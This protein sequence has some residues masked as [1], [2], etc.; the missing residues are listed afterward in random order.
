[1]L[2]HQG[3][4][5]GNEPT[6]LPRPKH[7]EAPLGFSQLA[8]WQLYELGH[9]HA[10]RTVSSATRLLGALDVRLL[11]QSLTQLAHRHEALRTRI[12]I[13]AGTPVQIIDEARGVELEFAD[14]SGRSAHDAESSI[15]REIEQLIL[16]P[17]D[18]SAGPLFSARLL[19]LGEHEHVFIVAMEHSIADGFSL[20]VL[21][22]D[23]FT[24]YEAAVAR[25]ASTLPTLQMQLADFAYWQ[26]HAQITC[27]QKHLAYWDTQLQGCGRLRFPEDR[28]ASAGATLG[29]GTVSIRIQRELKAELLEWCRARR[30]TLVLTLFTVYVAL[31]LRWC[32]ECDAVFQYQINGRFSPAIEN[33]IGYFASVLYLRMQLLEDDGFSEL[34]TRATRTYCEAYEHADGSYLATR[35]PR[36]EYMRNTVFNWIPRSTPEVSSGLSQGLQSSLNYSPVRFTFPAPP[37]FEL[38]REPF[39]LFADTGD[40]VLAD[41]YF[42]RSR[43]SLEL[44]ERFA[45]SFVVFATAMVRQ[46]QQRI[47]DIALAR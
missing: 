9:R 41:V 5:T 24:L 6:I 14:L 21:A 28:C 36:P 12:V 11:Q 45:R 30:T 32:G 37:D 25:Q 16:R 17:I 15:D 43:F 18:V 23:V 33:T 29:R 2:E 44:M 19:K 46:P 40:E 8:H 39:A 20:G 22:R 27:I 7:E 31:V 1:L 10:I 26:R 13:R 47:Q 35:V 42:S 4:T 34:L 38:D 3:Q